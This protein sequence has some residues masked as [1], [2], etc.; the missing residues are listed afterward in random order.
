MFGLLKCELNLPRNI[1]VLVLILWFQFAL[2]F[3]N[4]KFRAD[5][6]AKYSVLF[7]LHSFQVYV[8]IKYLVSVLIIYW[9]HSESEKLH[10]AKFLFHHHG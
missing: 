9:K 1:F 7:K 5:A 4:K 3:G 2:F 10:K 8:L 6:T